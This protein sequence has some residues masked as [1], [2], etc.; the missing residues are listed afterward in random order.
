MTLNNLPASIANNPFYL[1]GCTT[2]DSKAKILDLSNQAR[3]EAG[4]ETRQQACAILMHPKNRLDAELSW[5]PGGLSLQFIENLLSSSQTLIV[6]NPSYMPPIARIN[7]MVALIESLDA[8]SSLWI[9]YIVILA[10]VLN[11]ID[12]YIV[13]DNINQDRA[14][15]NFP[16]IKD[17]ELI[18]QGLRAS[19]ANCK[20]IVMKALDRLPTLKIIKIMDG[21]VS[22]TTENGRSY[23]YHLIH[24][25]VEGYEAEVSS[26]L[27]YGSE[28]IDLLI[29]Y[30]RHSK[31]NRKAITNH[32]SELDRMLK[33]YCI[34]SHSV[35]QSY[36]SRGIDNDRIS[37][38]AYSMRNLAIDLANNHS[39]F[40]AASSILQILKLHFGCVKTINELITQDQRILSGLV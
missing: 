38:V 22:Q 4:T 6:N 18:K 10:K 9:D 11:E 5:F 16:L 2:L 12:P 14:I 21:I 15:A 17:M 26:T 39:M 34:L 31:F 40:K 29:D 23:G 19:S 35:I 7:L 25:L 33:Q 20:A 28:K 32:I 3:M 30:V 24:E 8:Q 37:A 27:M 1:I 36:E 13:M